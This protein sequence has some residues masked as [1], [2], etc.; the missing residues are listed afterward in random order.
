MS[1]FAPNASSRPRALAALAAVSAIAT[2]ALLVLPNV[3]SA[4]QP[5]ADAPPQVA[6]QFS[7]AEL[8]TDA[9]THEVY[10]R[11]KRAA[12]AVCPWYDSR[13]LAMADY[14]KACQ[15]QAVARAVAKVGSARLAAVSQG[16]SVKEH[17]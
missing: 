12:E 16:H 14:A 10:A 9:G 2:A 7:Y 17:G 15:R 13:D 6:V 11:I 3:A 5:S 1:R 8:A 4:A